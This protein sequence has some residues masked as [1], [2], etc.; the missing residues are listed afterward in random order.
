MYGP[1]VF[2]HTTEFLAKLANVSPATILEW[3]RL[4]LFEGVASTK[5]GG[6]RRGVRRLWAP[7]A[8]ERVREIVRLKAEGYDT[9]TLIDRYAPKR[10]G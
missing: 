4:G 6:D 10:R 3:R 2:P 5:Q 8:V 9:Q 7:E 1:A